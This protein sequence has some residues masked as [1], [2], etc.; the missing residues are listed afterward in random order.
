MFVSHFDKSA[1]RGRCLN[2]VFDKRDSFSP[3][4]PN[5]SS[6]A[7]ANDR[8][9]LGAYSVNWPRRFPYSGSF[10]RNFIPMYLHLKIHLKIHPIVENLVIDAGKTVRED[11]KFVRAAVSR[12]R[13]L[14]S[15]HFAI[16]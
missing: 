4:N 14:R 15:L 3:C 6:T 2:W 11:A 7:E 5:I 9:L 16:S 12:D 1:S 13:A 10:P 8:C